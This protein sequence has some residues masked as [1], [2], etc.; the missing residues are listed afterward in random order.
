MAKKFTHNINI[1]FSFLLLLASSCSSGGSDGS[2]AVS[3]DEETAQLF[4]ARCGLIDNGT[5]IERPSR[6]EMVSVEVIGADA[7][8]I[9][10]ETGSEAGNA[11]LVKLHGISTEGISSYRI[12][13]GM[14]LLKSRLSSGA[15]FISAGRNCDI[16]MEGGGAGILGQ[17]Y[18]LD[19]ENMSELMLMHQSAIPKVDT[20]EGGAISECYKKIEPLDRPLS[21]IELDMQTVSFPTF[22]GNVKDGLIE[23][24][25]TKAELVRIIPLSSTQVVATP[26]LGLNA[27]NAMQIQ[28]HG[29]TTE[30]LSSTA[31]R[32]GLNFIASAASPEAYLVRV[33]NAC[34]IEIEGSGKA[35][36]GYI[37]SKDGTSI[38]EELLKRGYA[39]SGNEICDGDLLS[40]CYQILSADAP[41]IEDA[42][43]SPVN[44]SPLNPSQGHHDEETGFPPEDG[45]HENRIRNFLWKPVSESNGRVVVLVNPVNVRV[46]ARGAFNDTLSNSGPSNGRG[47]TAR[48]SRPGCGYG[49]NIT[50][51]FFNAQ[52]EQIPVVGGD[53][54]SVTIPNGCNRVEF[55]R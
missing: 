2:N 12:H 20:C 36:T 33:S 43:P 5:F 21:D 26:L 28:L 40:E 17:I 29:L 45:F 34:E 32:L 44:P 41:V 4:S 50:L 15:Y 52:N 31:N 39:K 10:R 38:N 55:R 54:M 37:F 8:I 6:A 48:G 27:G 51:T 42:L 14:E 53:G 3:L 22:C 35:T 11:Q 9:T 16:I 18:S 49:T 46:E 47:T 19:G 24:P 1:F 7:V 25:S 30:G 23:N 13:H